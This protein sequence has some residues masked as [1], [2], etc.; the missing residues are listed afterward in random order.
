MNEALAAAR[1]SAA[2][3]AELVLLFVA[4]SFLVALA[5]R[6]LGADRIRRWMGG[7]PLAG[8]LKG[9]ALGVVTPFCSYSTIPVLVGL[10]DAEVRLATAA[11]FVVASPVLDPLLLAAIALLFGSAPAA[12]YAA[13]T[14]TGAL[15]AGLV[16]DRLVA[17]ARPTPELVTL[18]PRGVTEVTSDGC[19]AGD[20]GRPPPWRGLRAE[21][22]DAW[23]SAL[24]TT[25][26]LLPSVVA[27]VLVGAVVSVAIPPN[28]LAR[29]AGPGNP[30]A[31]PAAALLGVP[32]Y[33][34]AEALLPVGVAL[35]DKGVGLGPVFAL[36]IAGAGVS[37]PELGM[38]AGILGPRL[39][40]ALVAVVFAVA[41]AGGLLIPLV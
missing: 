12:G 27:A 26:A 20:R 33:V 35:L 24:A 1:V 21:S 5:D 10:L 32:L 11:A 19:R 14:A 18:V 38:L 2:I 16:A 23:R 40:A 9:V 3:L 15:L 7:G 36:L 39:V 22:R 25:R 4:V 17:V 13:V 30:L 29:L 6:R 41:V 31:V 37:L 34:G 28:V 8:A